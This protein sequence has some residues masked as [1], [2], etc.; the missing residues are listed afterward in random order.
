LAYY[1]SIVPDADEVQ[2]A[3]V[4]FFFRSL[5]LFSTS[6]CQCVVVERLTPTPGDKMLKAGLLLPSALEGFVPDAQVDL[7]AADSLQDVNL[8]LRIF[9]AVIRGIMD[10]WALFSIR[11]ELI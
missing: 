3:F 8:K 7:D 4:L 10:V 2:A 1:I 5:Q 11:T 6:G 9:D